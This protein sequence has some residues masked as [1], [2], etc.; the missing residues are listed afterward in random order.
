M[1]TTNDGHSGNLARGIVK[2][3]KEVAGELAWS[4]TDVHTQV[5][6]TRSTATAKEGPHGE[7]SALLGAGTTTPET[8]SH[9]GWRDW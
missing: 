5:R 9:P 4:I 1:G 7:L 2:K 6:P 3:R 8:L